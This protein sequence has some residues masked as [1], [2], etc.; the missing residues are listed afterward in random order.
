MLMTKYHPD[1]RFITDY[2]AGSL[3][4]SQALC[5]SAH[6]HYCDD[7]RHKVEQLS[8]LGSFM[9]DELEAQQNDADAMEQSF[10]ELMSRI[11]DLP[12]ARFVAKSQ[13]AN[14]NR[15]QRLPSALHKLTRGD[16]DSLQ[17][18]SIGKYFSYSDLDIG[19]K[20]RETSLFS[21]KAGGNVPRHRHKGDEI[22][23][24][25]KGSFS[26]QDDHYQA[27][28]FIVRTRGEMHT[29]VAAQDEDCLCL[30]TLDAPIQMTNWFYRLLMPFIKASAQS[31][32]V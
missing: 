32:R 13:A 2:A 26:D 27:G 17:W 7:C 14:D 31:S 15:T 3:P 24:V 8:S 4:F 6:L 22:T 11:D 20:A 10:N 5:V 12:E 18:H 23:V 1:T 30:S 9:F 19:D 28:D 25:L 16:L 29:P 21:I